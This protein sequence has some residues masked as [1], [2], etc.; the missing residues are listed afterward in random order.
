MFKLTGEF[1]KLRSKEVKKLG[2]TRRMEHFGVDAKKYLEAL[3]GVIADEE[4]A[5]EDSS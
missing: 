2:Q 4:K 5:Y 1:A 3:K